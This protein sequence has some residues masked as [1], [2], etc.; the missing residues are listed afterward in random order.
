VIFTHIRRVADAGNA[1][2]FQ[3]LFARFPLL[4][5]PGRAAY[6][7]ALRWQAYLANPDFDALEGAPPHPYYVATLRLLIDA[8]AARN[9]TD[10]TD[11]PA[12]LAPSPSP[13]PPAFVPNPLVEI[14]GD[15]PAVPPRLDSPPPPVAPPPAE[16]QPPSDMEADTAR[17]ASDRPDMAPPGAATAPSLTPPAGAFA[18]PSP[19][20]ELNP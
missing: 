10:E 2:M 20:V 1:A 17:A 16:A 19:W 8:Y 12:A 4:E 6:R 9:E 18:A 13:P 11:L 5:L 3:K 15:G 7:E 14:R